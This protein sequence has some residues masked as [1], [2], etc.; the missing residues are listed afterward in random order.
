MKFYKK[1]K[2]PLAKDIFD[3]MTKIEP[4]ERYSIT[5]VLAHPWVTGSDRAEIPLTH[6]EN[7]QA[8]CNQMPFMRVK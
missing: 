8:F 2:S 5:Q 1:K 3:K 4:S 7:I 6:N